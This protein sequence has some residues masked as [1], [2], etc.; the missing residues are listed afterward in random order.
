MLTVGKVLV[1]RERKWKRTDVYVTFMAV[2]M[3]S[4]WSKD[5]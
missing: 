4:D 1:A 5:L 3:I 2:V